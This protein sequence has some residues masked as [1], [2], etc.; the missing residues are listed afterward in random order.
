MS[1]PETAFSLD[2]AGPEPRDLWPAEIPVRHPLRP[3]K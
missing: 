1:S 2:G 3:A